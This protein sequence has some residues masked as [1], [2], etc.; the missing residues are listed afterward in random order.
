MHLVMVFV[1]E[2]LLQQELAEQGVGDAAQWCQDDGG[3][4]LNDAR[5]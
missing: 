5:L 2:M 3:I 4:V 1:M